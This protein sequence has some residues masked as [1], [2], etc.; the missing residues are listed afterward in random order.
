M[1][2]LGMT[3]AKMAT[4]IAAETIPPMSLV[5]R[6]RRRWATEARASPAA[7][8][9]RPPADSAPIL[10]GMKANLAPRPS[11]ARMNRR[12]NLTG[13]APAQAADQIAAIFFSS[14]NDSRTFP[15]R[16]STSGKAFQ[17]PVNPMP[18]TPDME[19]TATESEEFAPSGISG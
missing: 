17:S 7:I 19:I 2:I 11:Q 9:Y 5:L 15:A 6:P 4:T 10:R 16:T 1:A 13:A 14:S 18:R 8:K 3:S 12:P